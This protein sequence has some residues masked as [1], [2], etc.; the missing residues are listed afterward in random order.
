MIPCLAARP[1]FS[2]AR[3]RPCFRRTSI[4]FSIS[5]L[6]AARAFLHS[7]MPTPVRSRRSFTSEAVIVMPC[8]FL[9]VL[10]SLPGR[11]R[12]G[13]GARDDVGYRGPFGRVLRRHHVRSL[14]GFLAGAQ[15]R[16]AHESREEADRP[17]RVVVPRERIVDHLGIAVRIDHAD[18]RNRE[19]IG[20]RDRDALL[21]G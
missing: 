8:S 13:S 4:A 1:D 3:E 14:L 21:L 12:G 6:A 18:H 10:G 7:I 9:T 5:P 19:P 20:L 11:T 17:D 15:N 16:I 2:D